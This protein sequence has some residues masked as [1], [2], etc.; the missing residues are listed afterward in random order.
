MSGTLAGLVFILIKDDIDPTIRL[1][2]ELRQ[3]RG[4]EM[5][6][7]GAGGVA[8]AGLPQHGQIEQTLCQDYAGE[9]PDRLPGEETAFGSGQQAM[10]EGGADAAPVEADDLATLT[11]GEGDAAGKRDAARGQA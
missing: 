11:A 4:C 7:E 10:R 9:V 1:C 8:E 6:A 5:C 2:A 3:L